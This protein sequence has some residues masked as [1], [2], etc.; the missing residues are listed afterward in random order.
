MLV[1][2]IWNTRRNLP[3]EQSRTNVSERSHGLARD[4]HTR[5]T[6]KA[7]MATHLSAVMSSEHNRA[8]ISF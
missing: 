4:V 5:D 8:E 2:K 3:A 1:L 6:I 7:S